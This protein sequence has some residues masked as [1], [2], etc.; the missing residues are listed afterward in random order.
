VICSE[1]EKPLDHVASYLKRGVC[2]S[3]NTRL[4]SELQVVLPP[5]A[6]FYEFS[7]LER[8]FH[9][10]EAARNGRRAA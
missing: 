1:C 5:G 9:F 10:R 3:C 6:K 4:L 2:S 8:R 7:F